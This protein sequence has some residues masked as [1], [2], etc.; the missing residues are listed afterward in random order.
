[1]RVERKIALSEVYKGR[2]YYFCM[3][4]YKRAFEARPDKFIELLSKA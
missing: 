3:D 1:M 2:P 4:S